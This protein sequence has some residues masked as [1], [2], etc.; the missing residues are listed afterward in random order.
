MKYMHSILETFFTRISEDMMKTYDDVLE[1]V[2]SEAD[3]LRRPGIWRIVNDELDVTKVVTAGCSI[4]VRKVL[5]ILIG[6]LDFSK[7]DIA[8][9]DDR[10][11][12]C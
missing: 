8:Q 6:V 7:P 3:F 4:S 12:D 11:I 1:S 5:Q 10:M 9:R 2:V